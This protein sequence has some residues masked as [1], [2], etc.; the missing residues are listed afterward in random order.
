MQNIQ[1]TV[2]AIIQHKDR[3]LMVEE[4]DSFQRTV[5]NQPAG[6]LEPGESIIEA[7]IREVDE[8]TGLS[9]KPISLIGCYFLSPAANQNHYLRFCF[10]GDLKSSTTPCPKDPE[11]IQAH[12]F[13][14]SEIRSLNNQLRSGLVLKCLEDYLNG[15]RYPLQQ[16]H[17]CN[18]ESQLS[19]LCYTRL[20]QQ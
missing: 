20:P 3:F 11:I 4:K 10:S 1:V 9:F 15:Q 16:F 12:W 18:N 7:I 19:D 5:Y 2:A 13:S 17:F 14:L 6:H 8:E